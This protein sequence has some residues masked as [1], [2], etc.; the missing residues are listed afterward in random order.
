MDVEVPENL[1]SRILLRHAFRYPHGS[2]TRR[3]TFALAAS[4]L[5]TVI[6]GGAL[7]W[8]ELKPTLADDVFVHMDEMSYALTSTTILDG[9][10]I[11]GVFG[12]FGANVSPEIGEV[13]FANVCVFRNKR[14]AHVVLRDVRS[15]VTV[16]IMPEEQL[17]RPSRISRGGRSGLLLPYAGGSL[18]I[19]SEREQ[20]LDKLEDRI[21][22]TVRWP[23]PTSAPNAVRS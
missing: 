5:V 14:V 16:I 20:R 21:R 23:A 9:E 12:W 22:D 2:G 1:T 11:A 8:F 18:A 7:L 13:S 6:F 3:R 17:T 15:P 19:V 4:I 10:T